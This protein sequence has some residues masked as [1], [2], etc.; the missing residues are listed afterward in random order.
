MTIFDRA[1][2]LEDRAAVLEERMGLPLRRP[3]V[4]VHYVPGQA[5][6]YAPTLEYHPMEPRPLVTAV[7]PRLVNLELGNGDQAVQV[8]ALDLHLVCSRTTPLERFVRADQTRVT[9]LVDA[10]APTPPAEDWAGD[11]HRVIHVDDSDCTCWKVIL[12]REKD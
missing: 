5:P 8:S 1:A 6:P 9:V 7:P 10:I 4:L 3:V 2:A 12:R 11:A